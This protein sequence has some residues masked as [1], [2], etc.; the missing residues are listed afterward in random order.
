MS[1]E[2]MVEAVRSGSIEAVAT[3]VG[4]LRHIF[5]QAES[6]SHVIEGLHW[7]I[8]MAPSGTGFVICDS[9]VVVV[10]PRGSS[11]VGFLVPGVIT[12]FPLSRVRCLRLVYGDRSISYRKISKETLQIINYNIAANSDRFIMGPDKAQLVSIVSRSESDREEAKP[13][14]T[15]ETVEQGDDGSLQKLTFQPR[16]YFYINGGA[17]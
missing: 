10:P 17:P 13:R 16:R 12:Y 7:Q 14:F 8:L 9:P 15:V 4:F 5:S 6:L 2:S 3:E 1:A 11:S